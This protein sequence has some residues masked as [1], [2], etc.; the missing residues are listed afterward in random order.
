M[1]MPTIIIATGFPQLTLYANNEDTV[2]LSQT[3]S[4]IQR[5]TEEYVKATVTVYSVKYSALVKAT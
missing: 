2:F 5:T 3:L 1:C 4:I